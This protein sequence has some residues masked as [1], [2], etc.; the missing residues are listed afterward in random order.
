ML[1]RPAVLEF[2]RWRLERTADPLR[3]LPRSVWPATHLGMEG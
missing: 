3:A 1:G 2:L